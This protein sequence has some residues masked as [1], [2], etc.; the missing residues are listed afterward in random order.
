MDKAHPLSTTM[1]VRRIEKN[2]D[3]LC[4]KEKVED[5]LGPEISYLN[6]IGALMYLAQ[7]MRPNI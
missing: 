5:V 7:Y 3:Q 4:P 2:I 1:I 6:E